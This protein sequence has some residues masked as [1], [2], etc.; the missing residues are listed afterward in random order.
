[1]ENKI[2]LLRADEI[3]CRVSA[4]NEKGLSLILYKDAR[5]DQKILDETFGMFGWQRSHESI[6]GNLYC[7]VEVWDDIKKQWISKEDVGTTCF[8][9]KEKSQASD[10]FKRACFNWS[11]GRELYTSPSPIWIGAE[12]ADIRKKGDK[13]YSYDRFKVSAIG[14]NENREIESLKIVNDKGVEV[15]RYNAKKNSNVVDGI[16]DQQLEELNRELERTGVTI[17]EVRQ[18][19]KVGKTK[20]DI[21]PDTYKRIMTALKKTKS[22][23]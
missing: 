9:E 16:T 20:S 14:Y 11:I 4:I 19:Y 6:D 7:K 17:E 13:F 21:S 1:M 3:E 5:V 18:R 2:R 10:S 15:F 23:A 8:T 12:K 22:A